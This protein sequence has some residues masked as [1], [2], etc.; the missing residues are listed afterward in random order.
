MR[1]TKKAADE[2]ETYRSISINGI[3]QSRSAVERLINEVAAT[4]MH[5]QFQNIR[6]LKEVAFLED[7]N[8]FDV[9]S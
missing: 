1:L 9:L 5:F 2:M 7:T 8:D 6:T 3:N 4:D